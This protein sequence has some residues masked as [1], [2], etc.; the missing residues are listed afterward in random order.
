[1]CFSLSGNTIFCWG[2][3]VNQHETH[4]GQVYQLAKQLG[5]SVETLLD[6]SASLN[7][8]GAPVSVVRAMRNAV[9]ECQHYPDPYSE[10]LRVRLA[11]EHGISEESILVSNGSAEII[12]IL[13]Q[14]LALRQ[15][16]IVGPTFGEFENSLRLAGVSCIGVDALSAQRYA[17]PLESI[18]T[19]LEEWRQDSS[20]KGRKVGM[21][22]NAVFL[23]N[24]NSPTGRRIAFRDLRQIVREVHQI[25]CW[26]IVDEA[27][28]D[29][30]PSQSLMKDIAT[31]PRLLILRSFTKFFAI[32]GIRLGY[33][34]GKPAVV[35]SL[36]RHLPPWSVNHVAQAA[37]VAALADSRFRQRSLQWMQQER[38]RFIAQLRKISGL[39]VIPS[40]ANFVMVEVSSTRCPQDIVERLQVQGIL[41]RNCQSFPGV[42]RPALR[43]AIRLARENKRLVKGLTE[44]MRKS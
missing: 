19:M 40:Q 18:F 39:R 6:F 15:A 21:H 35:E 12:R 2:G 22:K 24:P 33:V 14:A 29:W 17:P 37:G 3:V 41:V 42:T 30:S 27:F 34:V 44:I 5:R 8:L 4:G 16:C 32:P 23:C 43:I 31:S 9:N 13:P 28:V 25:G 10:D 38:P 26:V 7:P 36:R 20:R 1:M 11:Q